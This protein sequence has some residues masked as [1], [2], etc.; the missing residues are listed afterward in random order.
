MRFAL[1]F[2]VPIIKRCGLLVYV[3]QPIYFKFYFTQ[4]PKNKKKNIYF[5]IFHVIFSSKEVFI[6]KKKL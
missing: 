1:V 6:N 5:F 3:Y 4:V 2:G